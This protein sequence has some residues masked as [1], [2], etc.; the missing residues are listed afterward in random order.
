MSSFSEQ[1]A[2]EFET[3]TFIFFFYTRPPCKAGSFYLFLRSN[4]LFFLVGSSV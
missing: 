2:L 3:A 1:A 4:N